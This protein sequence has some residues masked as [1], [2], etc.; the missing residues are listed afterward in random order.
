MAIDLFFFFVTAGIE[1]FT[2][3][4][5]SLE[6]RHLDYSVL[7]LFLLLNGI[8]IYL[9]RFITNIDWLFAAVLYPTYPTIMKTNLVSY[10]LQTLNVGERVCSHCSIKQ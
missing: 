10:I 2:V 1:E 9:L 4:L 8:S 7:L 5:F 3:F 6:I